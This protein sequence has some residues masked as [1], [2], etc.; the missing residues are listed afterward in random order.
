[1]N[2]DGRPTVLWIEDNLHVEMRVVREYLEESD[3]YHFL[4]AE[5]V[6][7]A[8]KVL[9]QYGNS[10][11]AVLLDII[12]PIGK[13]V[14]GSTDEILNGGITLYRERLR[15]L[16][17]PVVVLSCRDDEQARLAFEKEANV[18]RLAKPVYPDEVEN[19]LDEA[20]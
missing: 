4:Y 17:V 11:D 2:S 3:K 5:T 12:L 7:E 16:G 20:L 6:E 9:N 15:P 13:N 19:A 1:M 10:L 14:V 8:K 18:I